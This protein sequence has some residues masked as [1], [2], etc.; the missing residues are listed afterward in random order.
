MCQDCCAY[1]YKLLDNAAAQKLRD[2]GFL[3]EYDTETQ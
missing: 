2:A 3:V 1:E